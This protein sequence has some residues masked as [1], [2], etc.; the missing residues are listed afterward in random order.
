M[1]QMTTS[2]ISEYYQYS[3]KDF[4]ESEKNIS[5]RVLSIGQSISRS[6]QRLFSRLL[7]SDVD[8]L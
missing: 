7:T 4:P 1:W 6:L 3:S 5:Y 2:Y 8:E